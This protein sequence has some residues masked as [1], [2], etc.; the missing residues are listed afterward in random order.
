MIIN[1]IG[2]MPQNNAT[3]KRIAF[4]GFTSSI[5]AEAFEK[6]AK[7]LKGKEGWSFVNDEVIAKSLKRFKDLTAK[8]KEKF[9]NDQGIDLHLFKE[10]QTIWACLLP[11]RLATANMPLGG[12]NSGLSRMKNNF[13]FSGHEKFLEEID[14]AAKEM[15]PSISSYV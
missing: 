3:N 5:S 12:F 1:S 13:M 4:K 10:E 15:E 7:A 2:A 14:A 8:L 9:G 6:A 11:S